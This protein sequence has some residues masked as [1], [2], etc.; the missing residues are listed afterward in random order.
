[1]SSIQECLEELKSLEL[2][3]DYDGVEVVQELLN[4]CTTL[5]D[6]KELLLLLWTYGSTPRFNTYIRST[7]KC[8]TVFNSMFKPNKR[9]FYRGIVFYEKER[10]SNLKEYVTNELYGMDEFTSATFD[11][12]TAKYFS[13]TFFTREG[14]CN[15]CVVIKVKAEFVLEVP[16]N[17]FTQDEK[18]VVLKDAVFDSI[19]SISLNEITLSGSSVI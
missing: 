1:M 2:L 8:Y 5:N 18:E 10:P 9:T 6:L 16:S 15:I 3:E 14:R 17:L 13:E 19:E 11:Y 7:E 4:T 12:G